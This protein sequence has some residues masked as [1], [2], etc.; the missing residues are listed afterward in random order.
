MTT[1]PDRHGPFRLLAAGAVD[2][3][4]EPA[5]AAALADHL[6]ACPA[7]R[8]FQT[9]LLA[10]HDLIST[11]GPAFAPPTRVRD[12]VLAAAGSPP[13]AARARWPAL[14]VAASLVIALGVAFS[15]V[16][17]LNGPGSR[18]TPTPTLAPSNSPTPSPRPTVGPS[19]PVPEPT[20]ALPWAAADATVAGIEGT[21]ARLQILAVLQGD[22]DA[23]TGFIQ[24]A[25]PD[26]T[27]WNGTLHHAQY[28]YDPSAPWYVALAEGCRLTT[29][30]CRTFVLQFIDGRAGTG[31]YDDISLSWADRATQQGQNW[32]LWYRVSDG[33]V[34]VAPLPGVG[35]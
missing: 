32:E 30:G 4:L 9:Q 29:D 7:C 12:A 24:F 6:R 33:T 17:G 23:A 31:V 8:R 28:W 34:D 35:P 27:E 1:Q 3:R 2:G 19:G 26:G 25:D 5:E 16:P 14:L 18:P 15:F 21:T 11:P 20:R 22:G 10:D 13:P